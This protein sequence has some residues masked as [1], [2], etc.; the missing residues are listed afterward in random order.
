MKTPKHDMAFAAR[1]KQFRIKHI[2]KNSIEVGGKLGI[3]Y[4]RLAG[5]RMANSRLTCL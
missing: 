1:F 4:S 5:F 2:S 3:P